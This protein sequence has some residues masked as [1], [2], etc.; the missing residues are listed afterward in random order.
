MT[1]VWRIASL[2]FEHMVLELELAPISGAMALITADAGRSLSQTDL[3]HGPTRIELIDLPPLTES[4]PRETTLAVAAAGELPG[5][6]RAALLASTDGGESWEDAGQTA[7]PA[8][9]GAAVTVL[10]SASANLFDQQNFVDVRLLHAAMQLSDADTLRLLAGANRAM[11]GKELIQFGQA[12]PRGG[13]VWRLSNLLR[14]RRG[15]EGAITGHMVGDRFVLL[16]SESLALLDPRF[17]VPG[18]SVMAVGIADDLSPP[19]VTT[20]PIGSALTP[21]SPVHPGLSREPSGD[22]VISW[23]RRSR[24][25]WAWRDGVDAPMS[26]ETESYRIELT[27]LGGSTRTF[28][29]TL[30]QF[31]YLASD[32]SAD[33]LAGAMVTT[34]SIS[35]VGQHCVSAPLTL[36]ITL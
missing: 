22:T 12:E 11:I 33:Q 34:V 9:I 13:D 5:W 2:V 15:T 26:E 16:E 28:T 31:V 19:V 35:Q 17:A 3:T 6:R 36:T 4:A 30:P 14:G 1:E 18:V 24:E 29:E 8:I 20:T 23:T 25:G 27:P 10:G 7:A 21:L 32:R